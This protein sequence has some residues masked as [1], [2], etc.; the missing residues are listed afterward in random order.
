MTREVKLTFLFAGVV[1][2]SVIVGLGL[3][4]VGDNAVG[5]ALVSFALAYCVGGSIYLAASNLEGALKAEAGDRSLWLIGPGLL[6]AF[7]APPLEY[8]YLPA[9]LPRATVM[10]VAGLAFVAM[11]LLLRLWTRWALGR[12]DTGHVQIRNGQRLVQ[13]GAYRF[14]RHPGYAGLGILT[15]GL[16]L[17]YSSLIGLVSIAALLL[18]GVAYRIRVE[19]EQLEAQFGDDYCTYARRT[20]R[21]IP[22]IW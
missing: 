21:L 11:G 16:C 12:M 9:L 7:M 1:L 3:A 18:P 14:L 13:T 4:T 17:G 6:A 22:G 2:S 15:L 10:Q 5:W 19:E 8:L 20:K